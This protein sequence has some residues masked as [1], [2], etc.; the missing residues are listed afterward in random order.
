[1]INVLDG[2]AGVIMPEDVAAD[3]LAG[4]VVANFRQLSARDLDRAEV[5]RRADQARILRV[6][7]FLH[8]NEGD[9]AL[10]GIEHPC[11]V[12]QALA[13]GRH[14]V[15]EIGRIVGLEALIALP[16][17][18]LALFGDLEILAVEEIERIFLALIHHDVEMLPRQLMAQRRAV[19]AQADEFTLLRCVFT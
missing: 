12:D 9:Q 18:G 17:I 8:Q 6:E 3:H 16:D 4:K 19:L 5:R 14:D 13:G 2:E 10:R 7:C 11:V 15:D 1:M